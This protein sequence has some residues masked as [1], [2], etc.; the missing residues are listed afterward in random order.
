MTNIHKKI[1]EEGDAR[2]MLLKFYPGVCIPPL[3]SKKLGKR[4]FEEEYIIKRMTFLNQFLQAIV[5]HHLLKS[6]DIV[7]NFLNT[8]DR[9]VFEKKLMI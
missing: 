8:K 6:S 3:P 7:Y 5:D 1:Y 9:L 4:R 2:E